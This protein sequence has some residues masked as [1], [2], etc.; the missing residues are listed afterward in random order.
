MYQP[1][2]FREDRLER[3]H[4]LIRSHPLGLLVTAGPLGLMANPI[5]FLLD[6]Q[7]SE[8]GTLRAHLA[9]A[10]PQWRELAQAEDCLVVFQGP[11]AYITPSWYPTK[12]ETGRVVPTWNYATVHVWGRPRLVE[13][14]AWLRAHLEALTS[15]RES[16][17]AAPWSV[18]DAPAP[19][20]AAQLKG[21]VGVEL[22]IA[23][24]EG[25]WK[26]SQNRGEADRNGVV[27]GP[28][29]EGPDAEP[30]AAL[31]ANRGG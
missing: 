31:V 15:A 7:A 19:F 17:R 27:R 2:H 20:V 4:E 16:R 18:D 30:M 11:E 24:S 13:D 3:H 22:P 14:G 12:G 25:K 1:P 21:I 29:E 23:R 8:R 5:P 26:V 6:S 10:N 9:R 28:R